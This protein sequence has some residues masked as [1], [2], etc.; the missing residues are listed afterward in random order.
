M[1]ELPSY[2]TVLTI[3]KIFIFNNFF[4]FSGKANDKVTAPAERLKADNITVFAIGV[5]RKYDIKQ[6]IDIASKPNTKYALTVDFN[7]LNELYTS[8]RDD[9][10]RGD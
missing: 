5:G 10:C 4:F 7:R 1:K 9:T 6:L 2:G 3:L 8:I